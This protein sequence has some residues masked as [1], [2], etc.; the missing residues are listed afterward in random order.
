M[1]TLG[2]V[3]GNMGGMGMAPGVY[4]VVTIKAPWANL[5]RWG[6]GGENGG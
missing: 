1:Y 4:E 2:V 3:E 5:V 6:K